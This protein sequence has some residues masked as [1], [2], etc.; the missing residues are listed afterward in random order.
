[1]FEASPAA[2]VDVLPDQQNT[3]AVDPSASCWAAAA[4]SAGS[5]LQRWRRGEA[6]HVCKEV[7]PQHDQGESSGLPVGTP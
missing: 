3:L 7:K 1:M 5:K 2:S 6:A 4:G